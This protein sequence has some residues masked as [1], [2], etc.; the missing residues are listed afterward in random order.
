MDMFQSKIRHIVLK[1]KSSEEK[2]KNCKKILTNVYRTVQIYNA[3][4]KE[5]FAS[6]TKIILNQLKETDEQNKLL[7][8]NLRDILVKISEIAN[9]KR[10]DEIPIVNQ[11]GLSPQN[12]LQRSDTQHLHRVEGQIHIISS[13]YNTKIREIQAHNF[14]SMTSNISTTIDT[15]LTNQESLVNFKKYL[16]SFEKFAEEKIINRVGI[17]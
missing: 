9:T 1:I 8:T 16:I 13:E 7:R 4:M 5:Y 15:K 11:G 3:S 14:D 2:Q 12:L 10:T 6:Y 17:G